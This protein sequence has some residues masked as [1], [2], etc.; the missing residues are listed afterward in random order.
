MPLVWYSRSIRCSPV[1]L[2]SSTPVTAT[3][4][5]SSSTCCDAA[6]TSR[7]ERIC[8]EP[9]GGAGMNSRPLAVCMVTPPSSDSSSPSSVPVVVS[10]ATRLCR[11]PARCAGTGVAPR[12]CNSGDRS[13]RISVNKVE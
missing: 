8:T 12:L 4:P 11:K 10:S 9:N 5:R 7:I 6:S 2:L 3:R 13:M 1:E